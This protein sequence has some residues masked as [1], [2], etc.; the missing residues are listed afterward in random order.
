[1]TGKRAAGAGRKPS[2][3][4]DG[5]NSTFTT[6]IRSD[7][8]KQLDRAARQKDRSLSQEVEIRL[9][10]SFNKEGNI[11]SHIQSLS[12]AISSLAM[13]IESRTGESWREDAFTCDALRNGVEFLIASLAPGG[14]I[15]ASAHLMKSVA[16]SPSS[17]QE[18][19]RDPALLGCFLA[20][21]L[22]HAIENAPL[23]A[24]EMP[25]LTF[26][27][28]SGLSRMRRD[29]GSGFQSEKKKDEKQ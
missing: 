17:F 3:P 19:F 21:A 8:R 24:N 18:T 12:L 20:G 11:P 10:E 28:P 5:K 13:D 15:V 23:S 29:I 7:T 27:A 4:L 22:I 14:E 9:R 6:R 26:P 1:M 25:G 16:R 2:G